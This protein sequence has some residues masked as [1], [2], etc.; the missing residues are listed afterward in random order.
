MEVLEVL[1]FPL[2]VLIWVSYGLLED[3]LELFL[4][5]QRVALDLHQGW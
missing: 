2:E 4:E 5:V 1:K 3:H